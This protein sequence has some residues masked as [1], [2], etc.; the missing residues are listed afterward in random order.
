VSCDVAV[1]VDG[2]SKRNGQGEWW[3]E[4]K[5][6]S[7]RKSKSKRKR[8]RNTQLKSDRGVEEDRRGVEEVKVRSGRRGTGV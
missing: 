6:K 7:K 8:K 4:R 2:G 5:R 1:R 3:R